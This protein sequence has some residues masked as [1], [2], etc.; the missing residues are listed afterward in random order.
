MGC[1]RRL[2]S[3]RDRRPPGRFRG[4]RL[5]RPEARPALAGRPIARGTAM[6]PETYERLW[7]I[8]DEVRQHPR[9]ARGPLL[10]ECCAGQPELRAEVEK[11]LAQA[12]DEPAEALAA[13]GPLNVRTHWST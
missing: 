11:L 13:P 2:H 10:D 12:D 6:T 9:S 1:I 8:F 5:P 3:A 4:D 7:V